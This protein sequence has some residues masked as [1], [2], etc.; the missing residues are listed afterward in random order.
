M[1]QEVRFYAYET[2]CTVCVED[3]ED[4]QELLQT[5]RAIGLRAEKLLNMYDKDSEL[6][7]LCQNYKPGEGYPVSPALFSFLQVNLQMAEL[8]G[9]CFDFTVGA[10]VKRWN[11]SSGGEVLEEKEIAE[12][13]PGIGYGH[14]HLFPERSEVI[15]D[16]PGIVL[17]PGASGKGFAIDRVIRYL[18]EKE[19][20]RA[21]L[22]FGG[23]LYVLGDEEWK[24]GIRDPY[25]PEQM[26][27]TI[28]AKN[29]AVSTSSWYEHS[30]KKNGKIYGHIISPISGKPAES[31]LSSVTVLSAQAVYADMLSTAVYCSGEKKGKELAKQVEEK[32]GVNCMVFCFP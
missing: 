30:L 4:A 15:M 3:R 21:C 31:G 29:Q 26:M 9:G 17:D 10:L 2:W 24:I 11:F 1:M 27:C 18:K 28:N 20:R 6:S 32:L 5:S 19:V 23:N 25:R 12:F 13:I 14:V 8:S 16:I 7:R 22:N